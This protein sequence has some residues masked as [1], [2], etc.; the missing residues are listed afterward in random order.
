[1]NDQELQ[2]KY[3]LY[4]ILSQTL[5]TLKQQVQLL[6]NQ[7][8]DIQITKETLK[9]VGK[10]K[11]ENEIMIPLG[12]GCYVNGKILDGNSFLVNIGSGV[13]IT[14]DSKE[15]QAFLDAKQ[16]ELEDAGVQVAGEMA[17]ANQKLDEL[18]VEIQHFMSRKSQEKPR[19]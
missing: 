13:V 16:K 18:S 5:E 6:E 2:E 15:M 8:M 3:V 14:K 1:M 11:G 10:L 17:K 19:A 12:S 9:D 4:Q 7:K